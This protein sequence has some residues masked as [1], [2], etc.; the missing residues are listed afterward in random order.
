MYKWLR[1]NFIAVIA[2]IVVLGVAGR[3]YYKQPRFINGETAPD[4]EAIMLN[5]EKMHLS[6]T[7]GKY[8]LLDFWGSW[9]PPCLEETPEL[10]NLYKRYSNQKFKDGAGFEIVAVGIEKEKA[11]WE[12]AIQKYELNWRYHVSDFQNLESP[13]AKQFG[14][15]VIPTKFL[16]NTE[17]VIIG[18]NQSVEEIDKFLKSKL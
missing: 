8:V 5:G 17:G 6:D 15:R 10:V 16:L 11:R 3:Y 12:A 1:N 4:F 9:C 14:V 18:V 13:L 7:R 2:A